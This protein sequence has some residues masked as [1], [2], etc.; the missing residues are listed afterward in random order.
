MRKSFVRGL[1]ALGAVALVYGCT[2]SDAK[3]EVAV[4]GVVEDGSG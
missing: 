3:K 4:K 1:L 2:L